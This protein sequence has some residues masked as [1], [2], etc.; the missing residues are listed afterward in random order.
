[1]SKMTLRISSLQKIFN[2]KKDCSGL[3]FKIN[4]GD[5]WKFGPIGGI[6]PCCLG[7]D[8]ILRG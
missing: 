6:F 1:M 2:H 7:K 4:L 5:V 8:L 3:A